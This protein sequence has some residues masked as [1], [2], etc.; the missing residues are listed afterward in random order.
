MPGQDPKFAEHWESQLWDNIK[1]HWGVDNRLTAHPGCRARRF[2]ADFVFRSLYDVVFP[3]LG[4]GG[5][6]PGPLP[7][8][9]Y[10][11]AIDGGGGGGGDECAPRATRYASFGAGRA[12]D[13]WDPADGDATY[14]RGWRYGEDA[15][16]RAA[17]WIA[18]S[19]ER[20]KEPRAAWV[21]FPVT[22]VRGFVT[23]QY[24]ET[25]EDA[26][27]FELWIGSTPGSNH[28][29]EGVVPQPAHN[30]DRSAYKSESAVRGAPVSYFNTRSVFVDTWAKNR[31]T[32][33]LALRTFDFAAH[34]EHLLHLRHVRPKKRE[35]AKRKG[36]KVKIVAITAC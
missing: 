9:R 24:L 16:G 22:L 2:V 30:S 12:W 3:A 18:S 29:V 23:V 32:S 1:G 28:D 8:P 19:A 5:A 7:P 36:D 14:R 35:L 11:G 21:A 4:A 33:E 10:G 15:P 6:A 13:P 34:G 17:G 27:A 20:G 31:T 26:G 25:Y